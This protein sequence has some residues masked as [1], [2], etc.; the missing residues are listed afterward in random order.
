MFDSEFRMQKLKIIPVMLLVALSSS[1]KRTGSEI[2]QPGITSGVSIYKDFP[3]TLNP[4]PEGNGTLYFTFDITGLQTFPAHYSR[5]LPLETLLKTG[6]K[7][8]N[9][10]LIGLEIR[11]ADSGGMMLQD[12]KDIAQRLSLSTGIA[13]SRFK[14]YGIPVCV[15]TICHPSYN[16]ISF[17]INSELIKAKRLLIR[18]SIPR[19]NLNEKTNETSVL[20][21]DSNNVAIIAV[22]SERAPYRI[23]IWKNNAEL[24]FHSPYLFRLDPPSDDTVYSFSCQFLLKDSTGRIQTFGETEMA[25]KKMWRKHWADMNHVEKKGMDKSHLMTQQYLRMIKICGKEE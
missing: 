23:L 8:I 10:G 25:S 12:I 9:A 11:G 1:C 17:R 2:K 20:N 7:C 18:I 4:L 22:N 15:E 6:E 14:I 24:R 21:A 16:M 5:G 3:D 19:G 13:E